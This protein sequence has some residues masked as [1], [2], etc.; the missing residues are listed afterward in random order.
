[1]AAPLPPSAV[2]ASADGKLWQLKNSVPE[3]ILFIIDVSY[4]MDIRLYGVHPESRMAYLRSL[5]KSFVSAK[6]RFN[7]GHSFA[8]ML[9]T[10][11]CTLVY[12][13]TSD[14]DQMEDFIAHLQPQ[15]EPNP[16]ELDSIFK[17]ILDKVDK[18]LM[19][20]KQSD[21]LPYVFRA[22]LLYGRDQ[23]IPPTNPALLE[24]VQSMPGLF[25]DTIYFCGDGD[26][27]TKD[28]QKETYKTMQLHCDDGDE[29]GFI[30]P[31][32]TSYP[33]LCSDMATLVAHPLQRCSWTDRNISLDKRVPTGAN[34]TGAK[35]RTV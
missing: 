30:L 10:N 21:Q 18:P 35:T 4:A 29:R 27:A 1:M 19:R 28:N 11:E 20:S 16:I 14:K 32:L 24:E 7:L 23:M 15:C 9:L 26:E 25:L 13:F 8:F 22:I 2:A 34:D 12:D 17:A 31:S 3:H 6:L 5:L 33:T